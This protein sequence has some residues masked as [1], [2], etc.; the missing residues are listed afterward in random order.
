VVLA[1]GDLQ[2]AFP[3]CPYSPIG[4]YFFLYP[5]GHFGLT[6]VTLIIFLPFWQLIVTF[7]AA[8]LTSSTLAGAGSV[9]F[10]SEAAI[11]AFKLS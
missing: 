6:E 1:L 4:S 10:A 11:A 9:V 2:R 7:L 8:G 3:C 5:A